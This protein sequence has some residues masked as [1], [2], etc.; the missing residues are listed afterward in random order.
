MLEVFHFVL[1][2]VENL[3]TAALWFVC[4]WSLSSS[5]SESVNSS[6]SEN[7]YF[8]LLNTAGCRIKPVLI[9]QNSP[10]FF[11]STLFSDRP[12]MCD[13]IME[14]LETMY[15]FF[16]FKGHWLKFE[17]F[18]F[19]FLFLISLPLLELLEKYLLFM[20]KYKWILS[21]VKVCIGALNVW[22]IP[23]SIH[24]CWNIPQRIFLII[25]QNTTIFF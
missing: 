9:F 23:Y 4:L 12:A 21:R 24:F 8:P 22:I 5:V 7:N 10:N 20:M 3:F 18:V 6:V 1:V 19:F 11:C 2:S 25:R 15:V 17:K 16:L 13:L 14:Q